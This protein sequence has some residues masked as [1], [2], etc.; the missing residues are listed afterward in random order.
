MREHNALV[1]LSQRAIVK[2]LFRMTDAGPG[3]RRLVKSACAKRLTCEESEFFT[4]GK[5]RD[6]LDLRRA[7]IRCEGRK[8]SARGQFSRLVRLIV[9]SKNAIGKIR[10]RYHRPMCHLCAWP[11]SGSKLPTGRRLISD[12]KRGRRDA[13]RGIENGEIDGISPPER[14][15][16]TQ[17]HRYWLTLGIMPAIH[18]YRLAGAAAEL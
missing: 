9:P 4:V 7:W 1:L 6:V 17:L 12:S 14:S 8:E 18:R 2:A 11:N 13:E 15:N 3:Q 5:H 10:E 16:L